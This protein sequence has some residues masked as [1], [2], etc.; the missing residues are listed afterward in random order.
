MTQLQVLQGR[1]VPCRAGAA[2]E[3][4]WHR[5][6]RG[7]RR[8][9]SCRW[10]AAGAGQPVTMPMASSTSCSAVHRRIQRAEERA[11]MAGTSPCPAGTGWVCQVGGR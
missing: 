3:A 10:C 2:G 6:S 8:W 5:L 1:S 7:A 11:L 9:S 4:H